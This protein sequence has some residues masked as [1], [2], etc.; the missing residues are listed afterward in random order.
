MQ[1]AFQDHAIGKKSRNFASRPILSNG[2]R[3]HCDFRREHPVRRLPTGG[4]AASHLQGSCKVEACRQSPCFSSCLRCCLSAAAAPVPCSA[5][6]WQRTR[7]L[8]GRSCRSMS[9]PPERVRTT[10][11]CPIPPGGRRPSTLPNSTSAFRKIMYQA[12]LKRPATGLILRS[13]LWRA[14]TNRSQTGSCS[15]GS[16]MRRCCGAHRKTARSSSS[17]T[18]TTTTSP[19]AFSVPPRSRM[20]TTSGR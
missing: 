5:S 20:T 11:H 19:T 3:R 7:P 4:F 2:D 15:S 6:T 14:P 13:I 8:P 17:C 10:C 9:R 16:S 1:P 18:A 12:K